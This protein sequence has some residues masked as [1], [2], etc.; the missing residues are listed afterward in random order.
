MRISII[1][2]GRVGQTLGRLAR[3]A[4]H[5]AGDIVCASRRSARSAVAFIGAGTPMSA[6]RARLS[7]SD[8]ILISTPD[9][10]IKDAAAL[11]QS[12]ARELARPRAGRP[13]VLHTSGAL[14]SEALAPLREE[15]F[16]T[17]S[18]HPLQTFP[19]PLRSEGLFGE[20]YFCIEGD[21]R[22]T[23]QARR[24][25]RDIGARYFE[26]PTEMKGLYHAS[27]VMAS[28]GVLALVS[29]SLEML[30]RCGLKEK[31]SIKVLLPLV[32][33][34]IAHVREVGPALALTGPVSRGDA[35]TVERNLKAISE[36]TPDWIEIYRLLSKRAVT[37]SETSGTDKRAL[38]NI[39]G[40]LE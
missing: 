15:G 12:S 4:G 8:L 10:R 40:L 35:G 21:A 28:P 27:A 17:G 36:M 25:A 29:I 26:I 34:T 2:A 30:A 14:S 24:L 22:A 5:E 31:E 18:C 39:R 23:R 16:S 32:E 33:A 19:R 11:I 3:E 9:D 1:G 37:L 13:A 7:P 20:T 6:A 38:E